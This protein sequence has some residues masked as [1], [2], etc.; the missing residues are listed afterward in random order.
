MDKTK[1]KNIN[2][3]WET[4]GAAKKPG[5][6]DGGIFTFDFIEE[7]CILGCFEAAYDCAVAFFFGL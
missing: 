5:L 2:Y 6:F 1:Y 4:L 3:K 7:V